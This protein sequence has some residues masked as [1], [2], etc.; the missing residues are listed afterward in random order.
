M[1]ICSLPETA[2]TYIQA[3]HGELLELIKTLTLIP[4]PSNYE[5]KR[6]EYCKKWLEENGCQGA[7]IDEAKNIV[8]PYKCDEEKQVV[9]FLAHIDTVFPDEEITW[10]Q[11]GNIVYAKGVGDDTASVAV[12]LL[13]ARFITEQDYESPYGILLVGNAGEEGLGN[14]KG[15]RQI[16]K[17]YGNRMYNFIGVDGGM[18]HCTVNSVGSQRYKIT[19]TT[20]GGHSYGD[21]GNQNAIQ[22]AASL[23]QTLYTMKVP[24]E[25]KTTYNV[26]MI[27]GGTSV[28]T[29]A[30]KCELL[31]EFRSADRTCL[32]QMEQMFLS[33][34]DAYRSM[35]IGVEAEV[36]SIR[37]CKGDVDEEKQQ[38]LWNRCLEI[39]RRYHKA[40]DIEMDVNSTDANIPWSEGIPSTTIGVVLCG[41]AHTKDEWMDI[42]TLD[43]GFHI[44]MNFVLSYLDTVNIEE[45]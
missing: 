19:I 35:E 18:T 14:L 17:D 1:H 24:Q 38:E 26:G 25:A 6:A 30:P 23:I 33:V 36:L 42:S 9:A 21:Y 10:R 3:H 28:N 2:E 13:I 12:L 7:Y 44:A 43:E 29:I 39:I 41:A 40:D 20:E 22:C 15:S 16:V 5:E 11:E 8:Y 32:K 34:I 37:P 27:S 31:Y 45:G 4:S